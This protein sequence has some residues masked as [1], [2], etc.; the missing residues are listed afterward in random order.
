MS[1]IAFCKRGGQEGILTTTLQ[2]RKLSDA[3]KSEYIDRYIPLP[4]MT[5]SQQTKL[6]NSKV[7]PEDAHNKME[8]VDYWENQEGSHGWACTKCGEVVQWG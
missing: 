5:V 4:G 2:Q 3:V 1:R 8:N 6:I 7:C